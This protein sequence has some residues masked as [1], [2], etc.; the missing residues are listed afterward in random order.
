MSAAYLL[1]LFGAP[2]DSL[3]APS[4]CIIM[5]ALYTINNYFLFFL[6]KDVYRVLQK[7]QLTPHFLIV[8]T[9]LS[10]KKL[11]EFMFRFV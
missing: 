4:V 9:I 2:T 11:I 5:T 10:T 7:I 1:V 8:P 3:I 6:L